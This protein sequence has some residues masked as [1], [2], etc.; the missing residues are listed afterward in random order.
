MMTFESALQEALEKRINS[1][2]VKR[3]TNPSNGNLILKLIVNGS[4]IFKKDINYKE[5]NSD[6]KIEKSVYEFIEKGL[7]SNGYKVNIDH[8]VVDFKSKDSI[9]KVEI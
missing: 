6:E 3:D 1:I 5:V 7:Y 9:Y 8:V 4:E 2:H